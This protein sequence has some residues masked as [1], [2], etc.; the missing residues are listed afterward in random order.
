MKTWTT[1][2]IRKCKGNE[3]IP[4]VTAYDAPC[5]RIFDE[6]GIAMILVGDSVGNNVLGFS[7]TVPVTMDM[8]LHHV[9]AVARGAQNALVI[10]DMP[11]MSYQISDDQGMA[12]AGRLVQEAGADA[13]KLEGGEFRAPLVK[14]L[15]DNGIPV[16]AHVGMTPQSCNAMGGFKVQGKGMVVLECVPPK[17]AEL[18]TRKLD[19]ITVGIGAGSGCDGQVL[20]WQDMLGMGERE[21]KFVK[22]FAEVGTLMQNAFRSYDRQV[23]EGIFPSQ[24]QSYVKSD[25][26][27][28]V[29]THLDQTIGRPVRKPVCVM[30][31]G[32]V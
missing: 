15:V 24:E 9:A 3:L 11:F 5:A 28:P 32:K 30:H 4:C 20:V 27:E 8:M 14:R 19:I 17:L 10:A 7:S 21:P 2:K 16:C 22:R 31:G 13:V 6:A 23:K 25:C 18:I 29:L 1:A 12:N 26:P